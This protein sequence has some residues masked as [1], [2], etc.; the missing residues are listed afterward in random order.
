M[1]LFLPVLLWA[2]NHPLVH[3]EILIETGHNTVKTKQESQPA[4]HY[5]TFSKQ[6]ERAGRLAGTETGREIDRHGDMQ[7]GR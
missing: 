7:A 4:T 3:E 5:P 2:N 6:F 1:F